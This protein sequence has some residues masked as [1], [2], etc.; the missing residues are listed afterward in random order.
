MEEAAVHSLSRWQIRKRFQHAARERD[1]HIIQQL[2]KQ[3]GGIEP[4]HCGRLSWSRSG[5][6]RGRMRSASRDS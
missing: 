6:E 5:A 3:I 2:E 4:H 1:A